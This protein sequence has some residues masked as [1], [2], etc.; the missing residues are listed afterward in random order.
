MEQVYSALMAMGSTNMRLVL[1]TIAIAVLAGLM[2]GIFI[3]RGVMK[4]LGGDPDFVLATA[5][6]VADGDLTVSLDTGKKEADGASEIAS[7][8]EEMSASAQ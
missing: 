8:S 1:I 7:S 3:S 2:L 4:Q 6:S 5:N